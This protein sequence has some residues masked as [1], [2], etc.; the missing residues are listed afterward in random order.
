[1]Q[2][3]LG[4]EDTP[5][6]LQ[7]VSSSDEVALVA[8]DISDSKE[9][10]QDTPEQQPRLTPDQAEELSAFL[11]VHGCGIVSALPQNIHSAER[12]Y[13][14]GVQTLVAA[15]LEQA[16]DKYDGTTAAISESLH[17]FEAATAGSL[18]E[19]RQNLDK[20][21][22]IRPYENPEA[23]L[24]RK[25][26]KIERWVDTQ[27][28]REHAAR[29]VELAPAVSGAD[30]A[31]PEG[32]KLTLVG[33]SPVAVEYSDPAQAVTDL[34]K[35]HSHMSPDSRDWG[36]T[37]SPEAAGGLGA[38]I[39][40]NEGAEVSWGDFYAFGHREGYS[41]MT[42]RFRASN[43]VAP[44][45]RF[46]HVV[47]QP[48]EYAPEYT[49][50]F[51]CPAPGNSTTPVPIDRLTSTLAAATG[52][53]DIIGGTPNKYVSHHFDLPSGGHI[54]FGGDIDG[55]GNIAPGQERHSR[56]ATTASIAVTVD[57]GPNAST[58]ERIAFAERL[59]AWMSVW[60]GDQPR[61]RRIQS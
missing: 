45:E 41:V 15:Y 50:A 37:I 18:D 10:K 52:R 44:I 21:D 55:S 1:L 6:Q 38:S 59:S 16:A 49:V 32:F 19:V 4:D 5:E 48:V 3:A 13:L 26:E 42:N 22:H 51:R 2:A 34:V 14:A 53:S 36:E 7:N 47:G 17:T 58:E 61:A 20:H 29:D 23:A 9:A 54:S 27:V 43:G 35:Y 30:C 56:F 46:A 39:T 8:S 31:P 40:D 28:L 24:T 60:A 33:S 57:L 11:A 12:D 25:G